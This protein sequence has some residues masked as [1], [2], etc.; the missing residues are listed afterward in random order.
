M[1][2]KLYRDR[3]HTYRSHPI[4]S[5]TGGS[6]SIECLDCRVSRGL[7]VGVH[8]IERTWKNALETLRR[9]HSIGL[10]MPK[11]SGVRMIVQNKITDSPSL[12]FGESRRSAAYR[13]GLPSPLGLPLTI[14]IAIEIDI[15]RVETT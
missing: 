1:G 15:V 10:A 7:G 2:L 3:R 4:I 9:V 11:N 13:L 8:D 6:I 5:G 12:R 14:K